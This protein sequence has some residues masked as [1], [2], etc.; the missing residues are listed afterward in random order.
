M[1]TALDKLGG[2]TEPRGLH[3]AKEFLTVAVGTAAVLTS[4]GP[5]AR[6]AYNDFYAALGTTPA[7]VGLTDQE[8]TYGFLAGVL[9]NLYE[10]ATIGLVSLG[11]HRVTCYWAM[12]HRRV[13]RDW[14]QDAWPER[15]K[16]LTTVL[17]TCSIC[18]LLY[19]TA[20]ALTATCVGVGIVLACVG[21]MARQG[22]PLRVPAR[23]T[24]GLP[25]WQIAWLMGVAASVLAR[26]G[27]WIFVALQDRFGPGLLLP[28][29]I[30]VAMVTLAL[31]VAAAWL[32][33]TGHAWHERLD[34][35]LS[36]PV[37]LVL[38]VAPAVVTTVGTARVMAPVYAALVRQG[39]L[40]D[41]GRQRA[42]MGPVRC[43]RAEGEHAVQEPAVELGAGDGGVV[44]IVPG[45][46][47]RLLPL[48]ADFIELPDAACPSRH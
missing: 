20:G 16:S 19:E 14:T 18:A 33:T 46:G 2:P 44:L 7:D 9:D 15:T 12:V 24:N 34:R 10:V 26:V 1:Y 3:H 42:V 25:Y 6:L 11:L 27:V 32:A 36:I 4:L 5:F 40:P 23:P 29:C 22:R 39:E 45:Q 8:I 48:S 38:T 17:T 35:R 30:A 31:W 47:K 21:G 28:V 13:V 43:V 37:L 41:L